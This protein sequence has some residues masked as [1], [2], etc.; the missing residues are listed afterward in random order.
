[1]IATVLYSYYSCYWSVLRITSFTSNWLHHLSG[2]H[3]WPQPSCSSQPQVDVR[4]GSS[5]TILPPF[6]QE[7][8]LTHGTFPK[9]QAQIQPAHRRFWQS[10]GCG[11]ISLCDLLSCAH[12]L[13]TVRLSDC[14]IMLEFGTTFQFQYVEI[15]W[16]IPDIP[17]KIAKAKVRSNSRVNFTHKVV[18][19]TK[20]WGELFTRKLRTDLGPLWEVYGSYTKLNLLLL[21]YQ[22]LFLSENV[23][24]STQ[25]KTS[26]SAM[27]T[28]LQKVVG[29]RNSWHLKSLTSKRRHQKVTF[30]WKKRRRKTTHQLQRQVCWF[31][32][33]MERSW[34]MF[35]ICFYLYKLAISTATEIKENIS[36]EWRTRCRPRCPCAA[37]WHRALATNWDPWTCQAKN[38]G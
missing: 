22:P 13:R 37:G 19:I 27:A 25:K 9:H 23:I 30:G 34:N 6:A 3:F 24:C 5:T 20:D 18:D 36:D 38:I 12:S 31:E 33:D 21:P 35:F 1:M 29:S 2:P 4:K 14:R 26:I 10:D 15:Y 17:G 8:I 11:E 16:V 7:G 28:A 32:K